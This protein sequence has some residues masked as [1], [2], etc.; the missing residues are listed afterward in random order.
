[1]PPSIETLAELLATSP[2]GAGEEPA[3]G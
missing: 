3:G 2:P 1:M